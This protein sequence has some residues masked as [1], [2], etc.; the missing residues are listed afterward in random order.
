MGY[1]ICITGTSGAGKTTLTRAVAREC[2]N[3]LIVSFDDYA[4]PPECATGLTSLDR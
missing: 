3:A 2:G 4:M 1:V